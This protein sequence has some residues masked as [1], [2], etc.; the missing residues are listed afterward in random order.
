M[1][2]SDG[3]AAMSWMLTQDRFATTNPGGSMKETLEGA[4]ITTNVLLALTVG[5]Q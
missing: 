4:Y 1:N 5:N 2:Q 3:S